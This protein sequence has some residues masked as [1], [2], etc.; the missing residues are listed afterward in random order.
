LNADQAH[1][2]AFHKGRSYFQGRYNIGAWAWELLDFPRDWL[3]RFKYF[4]EI[5]VPSSFVV[6]ALSPVSPVPVIRIPHPIS[7]V[8]I[9]TPP[10]DIR[11]RFSINE[12][13]FLFLFMFDY[14][15][16]LERKNPLGLIEAFRRAFSPGDSA[17]LLLKTS[18]TN[19]QSLK[20][21][22]DTVAGAKISV[23]ET[24]L[25]R[26]D[27]HALYDAC[28]CYVSLHRSE[29][30]GLTP[31]EAMAAGKPVIATAYGG[32]MDFMNEGNSYLVKHN[33]VELDK[34]YPPYEKGSSWAD[35]DVE[36]AAELMRFVYENRDEARATGKRAQAEIERTLAPPVVAEI[37]KERLL[38][39]ASSLGLPAE[40]GA[41]RAHAEPLSPHR[42]AQGRR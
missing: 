22:T 28:D 27:I 19:R 38:A 23:I 34:D 35:P 13:D 18:H 33:L 6:D 30:F 4:D 1:N 15:S 37:M 11:R 5:W 29:G 12:E 39:I 7:R 17:A 31:A 3:P 2:F 10:P 36:H 9:P 8:T 16:V 41:V 32:N 14:H 24:I 42:S 40:D 25:S 26:S 21:L 20:A